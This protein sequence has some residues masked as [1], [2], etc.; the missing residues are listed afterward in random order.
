[1]GDRDNKGRF[2]KGST[3]AGRPKGAVNKTTGEIREAFSNLIKHNIPN[4]TKWLEEIAENNPKEALDLIT[5]MAKYTTPKLARI[6]QELSSGVDTD[7]N[8]SIKRN[9]EE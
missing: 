5:K 2:V 9:K 3:E 1:M 6:E 7:I 8:I 4:F